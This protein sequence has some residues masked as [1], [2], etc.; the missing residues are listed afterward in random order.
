MITISS[1]YKNVY[2]QS[3]DQSL[4][5]EMRSAS[6]GMQTAQSTALMIKSRTGQSDPGS[7]G[8][9]GKEVRRQVDE[10]KP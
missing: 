2:C 7:M 5:S 6:E 8:N 10:G 3:R 4:E 9:P 1:C